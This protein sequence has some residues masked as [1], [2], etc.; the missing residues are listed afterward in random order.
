MLKNKVRRSLWTRLA[1]F[2][3][4]ARR[5]IL[6]VSVFTSWRR[7]RGPQRRADER[8]AGGLIGPQGGDGVEA[9]QGFFLSLPSILLWSL[10]VE[11][12]LMSQPGSGWITLA[13]SGEEWIIHS[14]LC[15]RSRVPTTT[16]SELLASAEPRFHLSHWSDWWITAEEIAKLRWPCD[17][18]NATQWL[19]F[20]ATFCLWRLFLLNTEL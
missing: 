6:I 5:H 20:P 11:S 7:S 15:A 10:I 4:V 8:A 13:H 16:A 2:L 17:R 18:C 19:I 14:S 3:F 12:A 1:Y 9:F